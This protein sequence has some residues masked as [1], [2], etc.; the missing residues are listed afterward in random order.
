MGTTE[1]DH[2]SDLRKASLVSEP[3]GKTPVKSWSVFLTSPEPVAQRSG[4]RTK[5]AFEVASSGRVELDQMRT[6]LA[7]LAQDAVAHWQSL[8]TESRSRR[9]KWEARRRELMC[10]AWIANHRASYFR[11]HKM[12][13]PHQ[14]SYYE[15]CMEFDRQ[16]L[17]LA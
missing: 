2:G 17:A 3:S 7:R 15:I 14:M 12:E 13:N 4:S 16:H 9:G 11:L 1:F 10:R 6:N 5:D 8:G